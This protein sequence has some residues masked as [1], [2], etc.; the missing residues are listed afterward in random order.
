MK[1]LQEDPVLGHI[2][3]FGG[4]PVSCAAALATLE[5]IE[6]ENLLETVEA[7]ANL[8]K[9]LLVHPKIKSIRNKGLMMAVEFDDFDQL[10]TIIDKAI[11]NGVLT[12]WFLHCDDSMRIAPPLT[13]TEGEIEWAC[14]QIL[15]SLN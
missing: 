10:K 9:K 14:E 13:I 3:T 4:H 12:D 5:V 8:F 1:V 11:E 7:K 2:T 15:A 6:E